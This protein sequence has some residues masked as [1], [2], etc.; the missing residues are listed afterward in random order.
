[1]FVLALFIKLKLED[2]S[3]SYTSRHMF[4]VN[5]PAL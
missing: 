3:F 4:Y 2:P 5:I 1:M